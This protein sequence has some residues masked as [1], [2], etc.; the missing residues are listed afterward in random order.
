MSSAEPGSLPGQLSTF[1]TRT[2][3]GTPV[4]SEEVSDAQP[5]T[6]HEFLARVVSVPQT[7]TAFASDP[8]ATASAAGFGD[9][10]SDQLGHACSFALDYAP[11]DVVEVY[12]ASLHGALVHIDC[13]GR[14]N[15]I[16]SANHATEIAYMP[17]HD[18]GHH[19]DVD[20]HF[21]AKDSF[22]VVNVHDVL[23]NNSIGAPGH[24]ADIPNPAQGAGAATGA[25]SHG[26]EQVHDAAVGLPVVGGAASHLVP[27]HLPSPEQAP[28]AVTGALSHGPE[29]LH[30]AAE[31]LPA[32]GPVAEHL[33]S[34]LP[35]PTDATSHL[36]SL[37]GHG[38][39]AAL[40]APIENAADNLPGVGE[41]AG[42]LPLD[43]L[44][45]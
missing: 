34:H 33:P 3:S 37:A 20:K 32:V 23:S 28:A 22:N 45:G 14:G 25:L 27:E 16:N 26:A 11:A 31:N 35:S 17:H 36:S 18:F 2:S 41:V 38:P 40:G 21:M 4:P 1:E 7:R 39:T 13:A 29:Q 12:R 30:A 5:C 8:A 6:M 42:H 10:D 44:H 15:A 24:G 43:G 19:G 9:L